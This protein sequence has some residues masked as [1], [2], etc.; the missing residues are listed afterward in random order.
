MKKPYLKPQ[1]SV[2]MIEPKKFLPLA[3]RQ[4]QVVL[5][6]I[7]ILHQATETTFGSKKSNNA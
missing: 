7:T 2:M 6:P 1:I 3:V 4:Q 5:P